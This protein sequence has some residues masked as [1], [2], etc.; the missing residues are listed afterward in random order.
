MVRELYP[1][2]RAR[3]ATPARAG[4][5]LVPAGL[6]AVRA[7]RRTARRDRR[8][9]VVPQRVTYHPTCHSLRVTRVG[10]AP[11]TAARRVRGLELVPLPDAT[12]CCGFG[13]TFSIKNADTSTAMV[14]DKC[15]C[16]RVDR[17]RGVHG[18]R[19]V[20]PAAD[21]RPALAGGPGVRTMH[22]AEILARSRSRESSGFPTAATRGARRTRSCARTCAAR[23][24]DPR[25]ARAGRR[26]AARL[27]GAPRGG[28]R[29]QGRRA[30]APRRVPGAVRGGRDRGGRPGALGARRGRGEPRRARG[31]ARP[32]RDRGREGE[33]AHDRRD[34]AQR[35][36]RGR[37]AS[38]RSR[39]TSPS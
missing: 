2:S 4:G 11:L 28:P 6:R 10:D 21:R 26:R 30:R 23:R 9:R 19:R 27:G 39:P 12:E 36:A 16:D 8:R 20:V 34:R 25:Q 31:R 17:R 13:G 3:P 22:L 33:V 15:A 24:D 1:G 18:G 38:T 14:V 29:D 37:A 35:R 7:A 32:R 5:R